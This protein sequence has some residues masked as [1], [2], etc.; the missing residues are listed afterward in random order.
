MRILTFS[1]L[2]LGDYRSSPEYDAD[3]LANFK[4]LAGLKMIFNSHVPTAQTTIARA[5]EP[6][7]YLIQSNLIKELA[8]EYAEFA[9]FL[10]G[11]F[12]VPPE[13]PRQE[14]EILMLMAGCYKIDP[15]KSFESYFRIIDIDDS[16]ITVQTINNSMQNILPVFETTHKSMLK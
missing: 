13:L 11:H 8:E 15:T 5:I 14:S 12:H 7:I 2:H 3:N 10:G 9:I 4:K 1:D 16:N 6:G